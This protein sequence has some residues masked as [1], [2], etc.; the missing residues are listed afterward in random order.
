MH[1]QP[2]PMAFWFIPSQAYR[3]EALS[4]R[5]WPGTKSTDSE[6]PK[7]TS[8]VEW[9]NLWPLTSRLVY[10]ISS[11]PT[12][13]LLLLSW[14]WKAP[15]FGVF[16]IVSMVQDSHSE[17]QWSSVTWPTLVGWD[18]ISSSRHLRMTLFGELFPPRQRWRKN[19]SAQKSLIS[20]P[21]TLLVKRTMKKNCLRSSAT[22]SACATKIG[23]SSHR[24][25][26]AERES[27]VKRIYIYI[28]IYYIYYTVL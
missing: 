4:G 25:G 2:H 3:R 7:S 16:W 15:H 5:L 6:H 21:N 23:G 9:A 19:L 18:L 24:E 20:T 17:I 14:W 8:S 13:E 28:C 12:G 26:Q 10:P 11:C 27:R 1:E 22:L